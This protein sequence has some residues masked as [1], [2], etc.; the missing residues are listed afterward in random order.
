MTNIGLRAVLLASLALLAF[1]SIPVAASS[2]EELF[3]AEVSHSMNT[4][5]SAMSVKPSGDVDKDFVDQMI[6]HHQ[7]A[8]DMA[9]SE[10]RYGRNVKVRRIA[11]EIIVTQ[12]QEIAAMR[13]ALGERL[14]SSATATVQN[15]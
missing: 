13:Q 5:M 6:P 4:M 2:T 8:I 9:V 3:N 12:E 15:P 1:K 11:Q 14:P 7:G 10:L